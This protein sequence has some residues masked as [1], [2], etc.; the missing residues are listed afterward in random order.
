MKLILSW[1]EKREE[2]R[3]EIELPSDKNWEELQ[4]YVAVF[5]RKAYKYSDEPIPD[6][7]D[8]ME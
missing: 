3:T 6:G 2:R 1:K 7:L 4:K 8:I 5:I